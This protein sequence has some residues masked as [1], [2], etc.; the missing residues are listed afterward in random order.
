MRRIIV[1]TLIVSTVLLTACASS[2]VSTSMNTTSNELPTVTQ[3]ALGS[4]KLDDTDYA[5]T[6][7]QATELLPMWQV[8]K[9]LINSDTAAQEEINA[10]ISQ[11]QATMLQEQLQA[12]SDM[13]L[14]EDDI[15]VA[16]QGANTNTSTSQSS[17]NITVSNGGGNGGGMPAGGPPDGGGIPPDMSGG[18]PSDFGGT[19]G[20]SNMSAGGTQNSQTGSTQS[21]AKVSTALVEALIQSLKQKTAA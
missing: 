4:L 5:I 16:M 13:E 19:G 18:M 3:L 7:E 20:P 10:L 14:T 21:T 17:S 9:E 2:A 11:I 6:A 12:I 1:F 15:S 8:Y